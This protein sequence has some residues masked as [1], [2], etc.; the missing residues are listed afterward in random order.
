MEQSRTEQQQRHKAENSGIDIIRNVSRQDFI[1]SL[2]GMY[3]MLA[4]FIVL[5]VL[6]WGLLLLAIRW[7]VLLS[8]RSTPWVY[9]Q[10]LL[11]SLRRSCVDGTWRPRTP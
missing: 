2:N 3:V 9:Y 1:V 7:R 11:W 4:V 10:S 6:L 8:L 5:R